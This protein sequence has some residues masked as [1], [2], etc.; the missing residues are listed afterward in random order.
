MLPSY[1]H[2]SHPENKGNKYRA[3]FQIP[4]FIKPFQKILDWGQK[5]YNFKSTYHLNLNHPI[6]EGVKKV[7]LI[8]KR[9]NFIS[10]SLELRKL[11][12]NNGL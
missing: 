7:T 1:V 4:K 12:R 9:D 10:S 3:F 2:S 8:S 5:L 6:S 11:Y